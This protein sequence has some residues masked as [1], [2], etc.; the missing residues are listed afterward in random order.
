[1]PE[2][3]A[4]GD[5]EG[6][7]GSGALEARL[8]GPYVCCVCVYLTQYFVR[9]AWPVRPMCV[10][11]SCRKREIERKKR[12]FVTLQ[13]TVNTDIGNAKCIKLVDAFELTIGRM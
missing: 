4:F 6:L 3:I 11:M 9:K 2:L 5:D 1:M 7:S 12:M 8:V 13:S 10:C